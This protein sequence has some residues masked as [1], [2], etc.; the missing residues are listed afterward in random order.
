MD[1]SLRHCTDHGARRMQQRA[2]T[3]QDIERVVRYGRRIHKHQAVR[4]LFDKATQ[5]VSSEK[6][7][8]GR[9]RLQETTSTSS[10]Y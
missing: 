2:I 10:R 3:E 8:R 5:H 7:A 6:R 9:S 4:Y 1:N